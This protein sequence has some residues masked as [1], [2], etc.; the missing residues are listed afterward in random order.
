M[1]TSVCSGY[2][3]VVEI[4]VGD[5]QAVLA[6]YGWVGAV[7]VAELLN[8]PFAEPSATG[9]R[10]VDQT[11]DVRTQTLFHRVFGFEQ[12]LGRPTHGAADVRAVQAVNL[13]D[14]LEAAG[15]DI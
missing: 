15:F 4:W 10:L 6:E 8:L 14:P 1:L 11:V 7:D 12:L 5:P 3:H 2:E 9:I 13:G